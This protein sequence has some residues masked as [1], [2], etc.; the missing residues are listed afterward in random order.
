MMADLM[1]EAYLGYKGEETPRAFVHEGIRRAIR[2]IVDR[3]YTEEYSYFR[4]R[5]DNDCRYILRYDL[6]RL[7]WEL[8]MK[9]DSGL[10][11]ED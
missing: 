10:S 11:A 3:W 7:S 9:E 2:E 5:A 8:V 4:V 1:V 6:T